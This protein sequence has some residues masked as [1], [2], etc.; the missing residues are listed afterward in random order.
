[1]NDFSREGIADLRSSARDFDDPSWITT[2][3]QMLGLDVPV[4]EAAPVAAITQ[5]L[6]VSAAPDDGKH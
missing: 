5:A 3:R 6:P 4:G 1:M 2:A